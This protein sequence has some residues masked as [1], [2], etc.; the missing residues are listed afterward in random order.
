M[1]MRIARLLGRSVLFI[2]VLYGDDSLLTAA[3]NAHEQPNRSSNAGKRVTTVAGITGTQEVQALLERTRR[4][5][6]GKGRLLNV[7]S[8][9]IDATLDFEGQPPRPFAQLLLL[10]DRFQ[11]RQGKTTYT[12]NGQEYWQEPEPAPQIAQQARRLKTYAFA[13]Q[14][15]VFLLR[16]P[17]SVP[18][19]AARQEDADSGVDAVLLEGPDGFLR[20]LEIDRSS[21][22]L[23]AVTFQSSLTQGGIEVRGTSRTTIDEYRTV[24]GVWFPSR[25]TTLQTGSPVKMTVNYVSIRENEGVRTTDFVKRGR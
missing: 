6:G 3:G 1:T 16:T 11:E 18:L 4:A 14:C 21:Y 20:T 22:R 5:L 25:T 19:R 24:D 12:I 17:A 9:A 7:R 2:A 23:R 10:P 8:L 13:T 15:V